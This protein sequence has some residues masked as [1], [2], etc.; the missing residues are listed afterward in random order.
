M[1]CGSG[2]VMLQDEIWSMRCTTQARD[3][4]DGDDGDEASIVWYNR[5]ESTTER[6]YRIDVLMF[7]SRCEKL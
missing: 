1:S 2:I 3:E 7:H 6:W 4:S 5:M